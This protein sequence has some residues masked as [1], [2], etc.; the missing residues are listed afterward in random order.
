MLNFRIFRA[1]LEE[2][3]N[4][5]RDAE[6]EC[7]GLA[8][9]NP[10]VFQP[11]LQTLQARAQ[12]LDAL[13]STPEEMTTYKQSVQDGDLPYPCVKE[14]FEELVCVMSLEAAGKT[15]GDHAVGLSELKASVDA[16]MMRQEP[17]MKYVSLVNSAVNSFVVVCITGGCRG[18]PQPL[19]RSRSENCPQA[20]LRIS[21]Y[22]RMDG[23]I[24]DDL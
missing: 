7:V 5:T 8:G 17:I 18:Q 9:D 23:H 10:G 21:G 15:V 14:L 20:Y 1:N 4:K 3:V 24:Y 13:N 12:G 19:D 11:R 22:T 16:W 6:F 2:V